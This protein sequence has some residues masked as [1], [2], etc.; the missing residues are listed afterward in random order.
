MTDFKDSA[1]Q[2]SQT[3]ATAQGEGLPSLT[4]QLQ[5]IPATKE[6]HLSHLSLVGA[7]STPQS[8][9]VPRSSG[10]RRVNS[11]V[12]YRL[13]LIMVWPCVCGGG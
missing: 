11:V 7:L 1:F 2:T 6:C 5:L 10:Q 4:K 9:P 12:F 3:V 13:C 8:R